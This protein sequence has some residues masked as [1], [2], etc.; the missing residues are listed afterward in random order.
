MSRPLH[1]GLRI[2]AGRLW[3]VVTGLQVFVR[4]GIGSGKPAAGSVRVDLRARAMNLRSL[5]AMILAA[6]CRVCT[7]ASQSHGMCESLSGFGQ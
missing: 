5:S 7:C 4:Q 2:V 1:V 6:A 3:T